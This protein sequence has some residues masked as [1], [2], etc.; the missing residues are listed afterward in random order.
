MT[1]WHVRGVFLPDE[2]EHDAWIVDGFLTFER[3][4]GPAET[5]ADRGWI[6]PG[7]VDAHC[8]IGLAPDRFVDDLDAQV[9]Q[10]L[11]DREAG[12]LL[13][14]D[15][16]SPVDNSGIQGREDLPRLIRA[17]RHIARTRRY[18]RHLGVEVEPENF[19]AEIETQAARADGWVK[20]VGDWIDRSVGDLAPLWP[21]DLL[22]TA[23]GRA[24]ELGARVAV[25]VFG[26][27]ALPG[28]IA[29]G[30]DSIEHGT[31]LTDEAIAQLQGTDT[32]VVPTLINIDTF[33]NIAAQGDGKYPGYATHMRALHA[34]SRARVRAA[35]EAGVPIYVGTD[36]GGSLL[37]GLIRD[38]IRELV[39]AGIPPADVIAAASWRAREWLGVPGLEEGAPADLVVYDAD[40]RVDLSTVDTPRRMVLRG[41]VIR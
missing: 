23:V 41:A 37:H 13:L 5:I 39:G 11:A 35:W 6:L 30:V 18:I 12:T 26:E 17:G 32:V 31:G 10:A 9:A 2:Q 40:P 8:H 27:D 22:K 19:V 29:A 3:Y 21:D 36:A 15:A 34:T 16:G 38:E 28:L 20:I 14:R 7:L 4:A 24:H 33:P 1:V 25:H